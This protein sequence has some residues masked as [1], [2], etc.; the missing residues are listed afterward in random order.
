MLPTEYGRNDSTLFQPH[1]EII[2]SESEVQIY[3]EL[4]KDSAGILTTSF[5]RR[6]RTVK[7]NRLRPKGFD[8]AFYEAQS[9]PFVKYLAEEERQLDSYS[10]P[11]YSDPQLT[12]ADRLTYRFRLDPAQVGRISTVTVRLY[13]QSIPPSYLQQRFNDAD[14]GPGEKREIQRL[15]FLTSHL[16]TD[17]TTPIENWKLLLASDCRRADGSGCD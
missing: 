12:G 11:H 17:A 10:D 4:I 7:D 2:K 3:Q 6:A 14:V 13:N 8:V 5:L 16:N 9:S 15:Y 1:R